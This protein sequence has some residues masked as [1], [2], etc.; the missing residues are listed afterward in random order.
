MINSSTSENPQTH[1]HMA[2]HPEEE[3]NPYKTEWFEAT[4]RWTPRL[5][6]I[7]PLFVLA[8]SLFSQGGAQ[9]GIPMALFP[10]LLICLLVCFYIIISQMS[11]VWTA[12]SSP[13]S[14][15]EQLRGFTETIQPKFIRTICYQLGL[16]IFTGN[17]AAGRTGLKQRL[18]F[19][20]NRFLRT[21]IQTPWDESTQVTSISNTVQA[22]AI[23]YTRRN[24]LNRLANLSSSAKAFVLYLFQLRIQ[25]GI[26]ILSSVLFQT[27]QVNDVVLAIILDNDRKAYFNAIVFAVILSLLL[28]HTARYVTRIIPHLKK[29]RNKPSAI[30]SGEGLFSYSFELF[31][32]WI[33]WV[34]LAL[35]TTPIAKQAYGSMW[36]G[37]HYHI[38]VILISQAIVIFLWRKFDYPRSTWV[39]GYRW[40]FV[41]FYVVG[42]FLP[43]L[44]QHLSANQIPEFVGSL[45]LLFW[46]LSMVL[47]VAS[48]IFR[49]S[50]VSGVPVLS[51]LLVGSYFININRIND[52][53]VVRLM[54]NTPSPNSL[55]ETRVKLPS[56][57]RSFF[58]WLA[59][60]EDG[61]SEPRYKKILEV[62]RN[63][64]EDECEYPVYIVSAQGGGIY[65]AYHA[66]KTLHAITKEIPKF[67]NHL[68]AISSVSGGSMGSS[69]YVNSLGC[70]QRG[71]VDEFFDKPRDPLAMIVASML[72]GDLVQRFYPFPVPAWD[73]SLGLELA[74]ETNKSEA[75]GN[76]INLNKSFYKTQVLFGPKKG[77]LP[78]LVLNTTEVENGR[79]YVL[80]PFRID[81][82]FS[83]ADFHEPWPNPPEQIYD[84]DLR[85]STAAGLS[86]RFPLVSPYGYFPE[87]K[88]RRFID[89]GLYDNSGAITAK[90][91][92]DEINNLI[93]F[94]PK[95]ERSDVC[96]DLEGK[97]EGKP[98]NEI[99]G[100]LRER[101]F[102]LSSISILDAKAVD[103]NSNYASS[104]RQQGF[105]IFGWTALT[106]V[107]TTR[108]SRVTKAVDFFSYDGDKFHGDSGYNRVLISKDFFLGGSRRPLFSIPLGW[109]LSCQARS[110][111]NDQL[112]PPV[113]R[114][115]NIN[116]N[117][118]IPFSGLSPHKPIPCE[119][120]SSA[121]LLKREPLRF[122]P[123]YNTNNQKP[124][125]SSEYFRD[126]LKVMRGDLNRF[127]KKPEP[128]RLELSS[129]QSPPVC[130]PWFAWAPWLGPSCPH[131]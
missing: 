14:K 109:K 91:I 124:K 17:P 129:I 54:K 120:S 123:P 18:A 72:F 80:S 40:W 97:L 100:V 74:F 111:I 52:N 114:M 30:S 86:A 44:F 116:P 104:E 10:V 32:F 8:S 13:P 25:V 125:D 87:Q 11:R 19:I 55:S 83:D 108:E 70:N 88:L 29:Y 15:I 128:A 51:L 56:L 130:R 67:R 127:Y 7:V 59:S 78:F 41:G 28:W 90:E 96:D 34:S 94:P 3:Y 50:I 105:T 5:L 131:R 119:K 89:G 65:A 43:F 4:Q 85:Y 26:A 16:I 121:P 2:Q 46:G 71:V 36:G 79:R 60:T 35:F 33:S 63:T 95:L 21:L 68:F 27:G 76:C 22:K 118:D 49:F 93:K 24:L 58:N 69:I 20:C 53:H 106:A 62:C 45:G 110:F 38:F 47:V 126:I 57:Q 61:E 64:K 6:G 112:Q 102:L 99:Y 23:S 92:R 1:H 73:R 82:S 98:C 42:L 101:R 122:I 117:P 115:Y 81:S 84:L 48:I 75:N 12:V 31:L 39:G 107:F 37:N 9:R 103:L 113:V 66:A 77:H